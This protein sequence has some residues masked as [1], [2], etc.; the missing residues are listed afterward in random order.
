LAQA[1]AQKKADD[2]RS[3]VMKHF[4]AVFLQTCTIVASLNVRS[5]SDP[6]N[7]SV[8]AAALSP[9]ANVTKTKAPDLELTKAFLSTRTASNLVWFIGCSI[10]SIATSQACQNANAVIQTWGIAAKSHYCTFGGLTLVFTFHPGATPPPYYHYG[11]ELKFDHTTTQDIIRSESQRIEQTFAKPPD[12]IIVDSS[13]WDVA[14]WWTKDGRPK[15]HWR[16]TT[17][18][19]SHWCHATIP[20]FLDFVQK[21]VPRSRLA[22]RSLPPV[23]DTCWEGYL[24]TMSEAIDKM[25]KCLLKSKGLA[26]H[27]LYDRYSLIDFNGIVHSTSKVLGGPLRKLYNDDVHPGPELSSAYIA[28]ALTWAK[29]L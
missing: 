1:D 3:I 15:H 24:C 7:V 11:D 12:A 22:F 23:F 19:T 13:L 21:T 4:L 9:D 10:D 8:S 6:H 5:P 25:N 14:N 2:P 29:G 16:A 27:Q 20:H 17:T 18:Q 28:A 26:N